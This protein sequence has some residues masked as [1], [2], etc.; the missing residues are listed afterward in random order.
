MPHTKTSCR[1]KASRLVRL[2]L[3]QLYARRSAVDAAI[4]ELEMREM[5]VLSSDS[6]RV[7]KTPELSS[8]S[9]Y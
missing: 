7:K 8:P 5:G 9:L 2:Q 3:E 4:Q 1:E 6:S